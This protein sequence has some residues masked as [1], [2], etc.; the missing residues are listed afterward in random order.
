MKKEYLQPVA[1][2][3]CFDEKDVITTSGE[4]DTPGD[5]F[6][7]GESPSSVSNVF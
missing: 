7:F 2:V 5:G 1:E 6:S 4:F 3:S